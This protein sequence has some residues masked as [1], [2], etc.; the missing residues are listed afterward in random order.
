MLD[1][2]RTY[3][4]LF[5]FAVLC[6]LIGIELFR[7]ADE[8][9]QLVFAILGALDLLYNR[10]WRA[11]RLFFVFL[12]VMAFYA[13]Y[14]IYF[15]DYSIPRAIVNDF[16]IQ[17]KPLIAFSVT[18]A[19]APQFTGKEKRIIKYLCIVLSV[20]SCIMILTN[21]RHALLPHVYHQGLLCAGCGIVYLLMAYDKEQPKGWSR[22][23]LLWAVAIFMMGLACTRAKYY[24]F[25]VLVLF[26]LFVYKP[27]MM[28]LKN[29]RNLG[30]ILL[31]LAAVLFV[32]WNKIE[33]YFITGNSDTFDPEVA[34]SFARPVLYATSILVFADHF[35]LGS[36]LA[37]FATSSSST[38]IHYSGLY[39]DYGIDA[40]WGLSPA[41]DAFISDTF[42]PELAQFGFVGIILFVVF[43][44]WIW[45]RLMILLRAGRL[46]L[47]II[48]VLGFG[49]LAIDATSNCCVLQVSGELIMA[50]LGILAA[51]AKSL[52]NEKL[53]SG[54]VADVYNGLNKKEM[55]YEQK[56]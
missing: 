26:M 37:S 9:C 20:V 54:N 11:Y 13:F 30:I 39:Y 23:D 19:I 10:R 34:E 44:C 38:A 52:D 48:G 35:W 51:C 24:G 22:K 53:L 12:G 1:I 46:P 40:I 55:K 33:Y 4:W 32:S 7:F 14:S 3:F 21:T 27:G 5:C 29:L 47:F 18:Y 28:N 15:L 31:V 36:G 2:N 6:L 49:F 41:Y 17:M 8:V 50:V 56:I 43:C 16:V 42:Y 25:V 45:K